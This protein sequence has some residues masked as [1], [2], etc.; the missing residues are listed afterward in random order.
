MDTSKRDRVLGVRD[1]PLPG[2][3]GGLRELNW[4]F[5]RHGI[6]RVTRRLILKA[7]QGP[8]RRVGGGSHNVV[9]RFASRK[10]GVVIQAESRT[11]EFA[12][13]YLCEHSPKVT[14]YLCQPCEIHVKTVDAAG[15]ENRKRYTPDYLV[16]D[17]AGFHLVEC[18]TL[19]ELTDHA[20]K[21]HLR[22]VHEDGEWRWPA[23]QDAARELG[24]GFRVVHS[25][26]V[27]PLW[28]RN[29]QFLSDFVDVE[30]PYPD[31]NARV[32]RYVGEN[33][34]VMS[35][36]LIRFA[37]AHPETVW[38]LLANGELHT[39]LEND[40]IW[41]VNGAR[42]FDCE[43]RMLAARH[44][45]KAKDSAAWTGPGVVTLEVDA[46]VC[47]WDEDWKVLNRNDRYLVLQ[48][49]NG[50]GRLRQIPLDDVETLL[51]SGAL[52]SRTSGVADGIRLA[53]EERVRCASPQ[54][55]D[56][57]E[58]R[59]QCVSFFGL[60]GKPPEGVS[61]RSV[62]RYT[63]WIGEGER[64]FGVGHVGL[65][66][67][68]GRKPGTPDM[69]AKTAELLDQ[70]VAEFS[71]PRA[72]NGIPKAKR[73]TTCHARLAA[74]CEQ[75]GIVAVPHVETVRRRLKRQPVARLVT[76]QKGA[77]AGY[78]R[79]SALQGSGLV[80]PVNGDR[81]FQKA[82]V[83]HVLVDLLLVSSTTG[84][85]IGKAWLTV[86]IDSFSRMPLAFSLSFDAPSAN[87][88]IA[89][90]FDCVRR[91]ERLPDEVMADLGSEFHS[92][93]VEHG[94]AKLKV[95]KSERPARKPRFGAI[96][97]RLFG[98]ANTQMFDEIRGNTKPLALERKLSPSHHPARHAAWTLPMLHDACDEWL[99]G[100]YP[101]LPHGN[102]G[103][104]PQE[105]FSKC[106]ARSG[107]RIARFVPYDLA[108]RISLSQPVDRGG[109]RTVHEG[110][111]VVAG[112]LN[113]W[114]RLFEQGDVAGTRVLFNLDPLD[115]STAFAFA[116]GK[117]RVCRL[118]EQG[119]DLSGRSWKQIELAV[120][121]LRA[122]RQAGR[123]AKN[124]AINA[125]TI[126]KFL[127]RL[128]HEGEL[129]AQI[130]RDRERLLIG[131]SRPE[132]G[133]GAGPRLVSSNP[134]P[135][136]VRRG[137]PSPRAGDGSLRSLDDDAPL[138]DDFEDLEPF[139]V[140]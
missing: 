36:D 15:R 137:T 11:V 116:R 135:S 12:F 7:F 23:A 58:V 32:L 103:A 62:R 83:D 89:V 109:K 74:L 33:Q 49:E 52:T 2:L 127:S 99:F 122:R 132:I 123:T 78:Q 140:D 126:G 118:Q 68:R 44:L 21:D 105:V 35:D 88:V 92:I 87:S 124:D 40:R 97:E 120:K 8:V 133:T 64:D 71:N 134:L 95:T 65:I 114:H 108:L 66:R 76:A 57:A 75:H 67:P 18:K 26:D 80:L 34:G 115:A 110:R 100:I 63:Q 69:D 45:A 129:A 112:Y 59:S 4:Y 107:E 22:F 77:R 72:V 82:H 111:G 96:I 119:V 27:N 85:V 91:H 51:A 50:D 93:R 53:R 94:F 46:V 25:E 61:E 55:L 130:M 19:E 125:L 81:V 104:S 14:L 139:D 90:I 60:H 54:A 28:V 3:P 113:Y 20:A 136:P 70:V 106:L 16:L 31:E 98:V 1:R 73:V 42:V 48:R 24:L 43:A 101:R 128:D 5:R 138:P 37:E 9:V 39:D 38:F 17:D 86:L 30:P 56:A 10:M 6:P 47:L 131:A 84:V 79:E 13:V 102:L 29:V 121:E 41:E 117:W